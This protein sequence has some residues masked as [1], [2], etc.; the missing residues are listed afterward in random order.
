MNSK[1]IVR[2]T[3]EFDYPER[4][5]RSCEESDLV[6]S[7]YL[8]SARAVD[9]HEV[10]G[11][12]WERI[13]EWGNNWARLNPSSRG[14][15][16]KG[17][18]TNID[19]MVNYEFPDYSHIEAFEP[20]KKARAEYPDKWLIG[21]LPGFTFG[22]AWRL[23]KLDRY[24]MDLVLS[25]EAIHQLHDRIDDLLIKMIQ[26]YA[27]IG[28]DSVMFYEDW[29]TQ[30]KLMVNPNLW[31]TE[32]FP[33]FQRLCRVAHENKIKV[34]MHSCG[35]VGVIVP[36]LIQAGI[37]LLQFDQPELHGIDTLF[38]YQQRFRIT[39]WCPVDI[40]TVLQS[41]NETLIRTKA[42]EMLD[43]LWNKRGGFIA[44]WY[45]DETSIGL[46]P[47]WQKHASEEFIRFGVQ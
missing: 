36:E 40:Q 8:L 32:F 41:R 45:D 37:D 19:E 15:I 6:S 25:S 4:V 44:G 42:R 33:R 17:V 5:A 34:F 24:L 28:V 22:V 14:E 38:S 9:W 21:D 39:F 26:N 20:V 35:Q 30:D 43:K 1:E 31:R 16:I 13:D 29:G 46:S 23:L 27:A 3:L 11:D 10:G 7:R 2:K 18:L 12:R 47:E